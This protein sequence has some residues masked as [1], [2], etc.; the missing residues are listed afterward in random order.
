[1][2]NTGEAPQAQSAYRSDIDGLRAIAVSAVVLYHSGVL[3]TRS[4]FVGVDIF[5]VISGFLIGGIVFRE[6]AAG[7]F[8]FA[9]FYARRARRIVPAL[10]VVMLFTIGMGA[11]VLTPAEMTRLGISAASVAVGVSNLRFLKAFDYFNPGAA[12]D[13]L[14]MTWSL[15]VEEQFYLIFPI[16]LFFGFKFIPKHI[17]TVLIISSLVSFGLSA[18]ITMTHPAVAF[19]LLPTRAWELGAGAALAIFQS[20]NS[21]RTPL[22]FVPILSV[23]GLA[24]II[25]SIAMPIAVTDFPGWVAALPVLATVAMIAAQGSWLNRNV[26]GN[27]VLVWLGKLSYSWYLWHWPFLAYLKL[28]TPGESARAVVF[29]AN[30][31]AFALAV[32][33]H[34][35]IEKPF[36]ASRMPVRTVLMRYAAT[37]LVLT[38]GSAAISLTGGLPMR[39]SPLVASILREP[40]GGPCLVSMGDT[41]PNT[42]PT[43]IVHPAGTQPIIAII[44]DSHAGALAPGLTALARDHH[45][46]TDVIA[47]AGCP[48]LL[49]VRIE[50]SEYP[51]LSHECAEFYR[52]ALEIV[53]RDPSIRTVIVAAYWRA[54]VGAA[55]DLH[56]PQTLPETQVFELALAKTLRRLQQ[57]GKQVY[58]ADDV[59]DWTEDPVKFALH[60]EIPVRGFVARLSIAGNNVPQEA[61]RN[62]AIDQALLRV[63]SSTGSGMLHIRQSLCKPACQY[64]YGNSMLYSDKHHVT[65]IGATMS[66]AP[67]ASQ[68][69]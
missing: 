44:G 61:P 13:P 51:N 49:E 57:A 65:A 24:G 30:L 17:L 4:G 5:F 22:K 48:P 40:A 60:D 46:Q 54:A 67:V 1:M 23:L 3:F 62:I 63:A 43:C 59:A 39:T 45:W 36:R 47:K 32:I 42:T 31:L 38:V 14:L 6:I 25:A 35:L 33:A 41:S 58:L 21:V 50:S 18:A 7:N 28:C 19:Y 8:T 29:C 55:K 37:L 69:F 53:T 2:T 27:P 26:L 16:L 66:L 15:G 11:L 34:Y 9:N 56:A 64:R 68:L 10:A 12:F 52:Q 20:R